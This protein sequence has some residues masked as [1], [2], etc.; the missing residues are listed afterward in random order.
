M[1]EVLRDFPELTTEVQGKSIDP[2]A[3]HRQSLSSIVFFKKFNLMN[4]PS[5]TYILQVKLCR[6]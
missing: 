4:E 2:I 6:S 1:S 5:L 3:L